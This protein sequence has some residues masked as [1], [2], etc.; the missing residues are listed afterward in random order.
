VVEE[1][2]LRWAPGRNSPAACARR[3][4]FSTA[5]R[6]SGLQCDCCSDAWRSSAKGVIHRLAIVIGLQQLGHHLALLA[7]RLVDL[8][9][10]MG[11]S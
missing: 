4:N 5:S 7:D 9:Q 6:Q 3:R 8:L 11:G 10:L 1:P 2:Y